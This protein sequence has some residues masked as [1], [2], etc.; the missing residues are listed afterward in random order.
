MHKT[1]LDC[2]PKIFRC[3]FCRTAPPFPYYFFSTC[4]Y[5]CMNW[6]GIKMFLDDLEKLC[7]LLPFY[8]C[9][10]AL[11][12]LS[13]IPLF[14]FNLF[15][16]VQNN[17]YFSSV[18]VSSGRKL[19]N[20]NN[21]CYG[22]FFICCPQKKPMQQFGGVSGR[23]NNLLH[24]FVYNLQAFCRCLVHSGPSCMAWEVW[25]LLK[26]SWVTL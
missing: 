8:N 22:L 12:A 23:E 24:P 19:S 17:L 6:N 18:E 11:R 2:S 4:M 25:I 16:A 7:T 5:K 14:R 10:N 3:A 21:V 26:A 15:Y 1:S 13:D 20:A 9:W